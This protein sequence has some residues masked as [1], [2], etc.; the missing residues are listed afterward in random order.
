MNREAM[1]LLGI[2]AALLG[3]WTVWASLSQR[4]YDWPGAFAAALLIALLARLLRT[5][6]PAREVPAPAPPS[7]PPST[8]PQ[9]RSLLLIRERV[10]WGA[11]DPNRFAQVVTPLLR[12]L[13]DE[14]LAHRRGLSR[15]RDWAAA[16]RLLGP[17][18]MVLLEGPPPTAVPS[19]AWLDDAIRRIERL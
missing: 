12:D 16:S 18:L 2:T 7:R 11:V 4:S 9:F 1:R 15:D 5:L 19:A 10:S 6:R 3:I 13:V 8:L 17:E 14:R